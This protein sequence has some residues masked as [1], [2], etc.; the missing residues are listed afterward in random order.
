MRATRRR[1]HEGGVGRHEAGR[2]DRAGAVVDDLRARR[3]VDLAGRPDGDDLAVLGDDHAV[4]DG[5]R[6]A[7]RVDR[8]R[9]DGDHV[10]REGTRGERRGGAQMEEELAHG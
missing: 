7:A 4:L 3:H 2:D 9:L 6:S 8:A 5:R 10:T 1:G